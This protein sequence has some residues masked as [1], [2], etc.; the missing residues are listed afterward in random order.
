MKALVV[1]ARGMLAHEVIAELAG[2]CELAQGDLPACDIRDQALVADVVRQCRPDVVINCAAYTD[3]DGCEAQQR[4]AFA[5]NADGA[6]N[7]ALACRENSALLVHISTDFVFDGAQRTPYTEDDEA[8]PLSVYG[9][10]K[11]AGERHIQSV[12]AR[13]IIVRTSWLFGRAGKNFVATIVRLAHERDELRIVNDQAGCPTYA[14]D[15]A[16]AIKALLCSPAQGIYHACNSGVCTWYEFAAEIVGLAGRS[17][18][19]MTAIASSELA[20]PA[21]RPPYSAMDCSRLAAATGFR[22]RPWQEALRDYLL[23]ARD[24]QI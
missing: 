10:S 23:A 14:V 5:V 12:L 17:G 24:G 2:F 20:R 6:R 16:R 1:G 13:Y 8:Q 15:L 9:R 18:T 22:F 19:R 4:E 7:V 3:V 11:L 21:Q